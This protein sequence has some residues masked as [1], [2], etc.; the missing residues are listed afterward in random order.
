MSAV[1][2]NSTAAASS[3]KPGS[4]KFVTKKPVA[5]RRKQT[6]A[7]DTNKEKTTKGVLIVNP[8]SCGGLTGKNWDQLYEQIKQALSKNNIDVAFSK[9]S[10]DGTTLARDYLR[11]GFTEIYAIGGDGTINEVANGFF[12]ER[13]GIYNS[14]SD[15][16]TNSSN[17][18]MSNI[19]ATAAIP[20]LKPINKTAK[21][22]ILP[23][24]TRN[25]LAKSLNLPGGVVE[26]CKNIASSFSSNLVKKL[27][28]IGVQATNNED[29]SKTPMRVVLNAAELGV[30][31]EIIDRSKKVRDVVKS[32]LVSTITAVVSTLPAYESNLCTISLDNNPRKTFDT[33]MTLGIV[34]NG[35]F[36]GGGF[37]AAPNADMSDGL[38]DVVI[39]KDSGSFKM[40]DELVNLKS[41][42]HFDDDNIMYA[43]AKT[44]SIKSK[45]RDVT[46]T[47][48]GEP[49]GILPAVFHVFHKALNVIL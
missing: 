36:L 19:I 27:D 13:T 46:V 29:G 15:I 41:G 14:S 5:I 8:N 48:D 22:A 11:R 2:G 20:Q 38:L 12:Q 37:R 25:V 32:R 4:S 21:L 18:K 17:K 9:K 23:C 30:A 10:G 6:A 47:L 24:G 39:V 44:V 7:D 26:S 43:Q 49:I 35:K 31:A 42:E 40:L 45:E 33:R 3:S 28:V 34:A 16:I 1:G